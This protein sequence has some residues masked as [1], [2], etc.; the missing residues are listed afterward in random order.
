MRPKISI[1]P[2][3]EGLERTKAQ[4]PDLDVHFVQSVSSQIIESGVRRREYPC[5][6]GKKNARTVSFGALRER[7]KCRKVMIIGFRSRR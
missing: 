1:S 2:Q 6:I 7:N 5:A 4:L 3:V